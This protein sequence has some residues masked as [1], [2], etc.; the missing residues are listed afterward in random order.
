MSSR[1]ELLYLVCEPCQLRPRDMS[2][3]LLQP[4]A[5]HHDQKSRIESAPGR[6][7][8]DYAFLKPDRFRAHRNCLI[9]SRSGFLGSPEHVNQMNLLRHI[10][11][12]GIGFLAE[13]TG[14]IRI[15]GNYSIPLPL[16]VGRN[17]VR[18]AGEI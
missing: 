18:W 16:H 9:D 1:W 17:A 10:S 5:I 3:V 8:V 13:R 12:P 7:A 14:F 15:N 4:A 6:S 2:H 11:Q